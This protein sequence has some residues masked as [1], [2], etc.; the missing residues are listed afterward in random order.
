M[1]DADEAKSEKYVLPEK[2]ANKKISFYKSFDKRGPIL[3]IL[4]ILM[5]PV[6]IFGEKEK[7]KKDKKEYQ[8]MLSANYAVIVEKLALFV[9]AGI[10]P[11]EAFRRILDGRKN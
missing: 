3:L 4:G 2:I 6:I 8:K 1:S 7:D 11:K 5:I 9:N 10:R